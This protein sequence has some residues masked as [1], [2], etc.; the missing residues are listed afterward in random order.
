MFKLRKRFYINRVNKGTP[1]KK[2]QQVSHEQQ[3]DWKLWG[4]EETDSNYGEG[5]KGALQEA[6]ENLRSSWDKNAPASAR[7]SANHNLGSAAGTRA[8]PNMSPRPR[9]EIFCV[10][11][12]SCR[13][14]CCDSRVRP[15]KCSNHARW[16]AASLGSSVWGWTSRSPFRELYALEN[17]LD[18]SVNFVSVRSVRGRLLH[19][20]LRSDKGNLI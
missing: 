5:L 13:L 16:K 1:G 17:F 12:D 3:S 10:R 20:W 2:G 19:V 6:P 14:D 4:M 8:G 7:H 18:V 9:W 11:W 15:G